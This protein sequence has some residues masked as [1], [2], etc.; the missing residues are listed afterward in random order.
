[1][2]ITVTSKDIDSIEL[3]P[4]NKTISAIKVNYPENPDL[5]ASIITI[6]KFG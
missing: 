5:T 2:Q 4:G 3:G 6:S 1:M